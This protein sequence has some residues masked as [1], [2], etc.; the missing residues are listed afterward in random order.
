ML[1]TSGLNELKLVIQDDFN[2]QHVNRQNGLFGVLFRVLI[3][4]QEVKKKKKLYRI[5]SVLFLYLH[6]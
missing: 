1:Y 3:K 5:L 4:K 6:I 2:Q